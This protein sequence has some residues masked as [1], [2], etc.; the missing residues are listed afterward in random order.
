M[1]KVKTYSFHL[2]KISQLVPLLDKTTYLVSILLEVFWTD[3]DSRSQFA[4]LT[5]MCL[6]QNWTRT[7]PR[8]FVSSAP[9]QNKLLSCFQSRKMLRCWP[10]QYENHCNLLALE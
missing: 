1:S 8:C 3:S 4:W 6:L 5:V 2:M 7:G 9:I 10:Y